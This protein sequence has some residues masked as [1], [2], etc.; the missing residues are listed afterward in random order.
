M[1]CHSECSEEFYRTALHKEVSHIYPKT[2]TEDQPSVWVCSQT[3]WPSPRIGGDAD[4]ERAL[5]AAHSNHMFLEYTHNFVDQANAANYYI[6]ILAVNLNSNSH[7]IV[8]RL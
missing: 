2:K 5:S 4:K 6:G 7:R 1:R 8:E 3:L